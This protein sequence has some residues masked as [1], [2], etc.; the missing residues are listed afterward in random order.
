[1]TVSEEALDID[2]GAS[3]TYTVVLTSQPT[4]TVTVGVARTADSDPDVTMSPESLTFT[5]GTWNT[6]QAVTVSGG[7]DS[8]AADDAATIEHTVSGGDYEDNGVT[9]ADVA[10]AVDDDETAA[11]ELTLALTV[12]HDDVDGSTDVT[13]GDVLS[14]TATATNSGNLAL[15][16]VKVSD[17]LVSTGGKGCATLALRAKCE[18][19]GTYTVTQGDVDAGQVVN[20]ATATATGLTAE[21][22]SVTTAVAQQ[23]ALTLELSAD[24]AS[25]A[26]VGDTITYGYKVINSGTVTLSGTVT[27]AD[28]TVAAAA[29]TCAEVPSSGLAPGGTASCSGTYTTLQAD[30]DA[31]GVASNATASLDGTTSAAATLR[32]PWAAPQGSELP[33][34]TIAGVDGDED[35]GA[36]R[37]RGEPEPGQP[38]DGDGG[39]RD[40]GRHGDG[41]R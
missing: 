17:L 3:A 31:S 4:D 24:V 1:M 14:Y 40:G 2:E 7:Q 10:V 34:L 38:A 8:D 27:I 26:A 37:V 41:G 21:T 23:R 20:T 28:D 32:V 30:V 33:V 35:D 19:T 15:S 11:R 16:G 25:F 5:T 22:E 6:A 13:L 29:I 39:V 12:E 9:A 36:V 18:L